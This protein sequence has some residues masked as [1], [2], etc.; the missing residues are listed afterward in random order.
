MNKSLI[1]IGKRSGDS[2][3]RFQVWFTNR[4]SDFPLSFILAVGKQ[5]LYYE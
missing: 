3:V 2:E 5:R 4:R 1:D